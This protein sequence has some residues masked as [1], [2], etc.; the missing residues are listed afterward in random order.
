MGVEIKCK[1]KADIFQLLE[2]MSKSY[3]FP[4]MFM[5]ETYFQICKDVKYHGNGLC[6]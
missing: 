2:T 4:S 5:W 6:L 3:L 1:I